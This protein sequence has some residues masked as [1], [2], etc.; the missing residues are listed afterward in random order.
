MITF[1]FKNLVILSKNYRMHLLAV[2]SSNDSFLLSFKK[3][4]NNRGEQKILTTTNL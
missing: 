4:V 3:N 2:F 1:V